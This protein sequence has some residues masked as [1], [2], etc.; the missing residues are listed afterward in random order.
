MFITPSGVYKIN[1]HILYIMANQSFRIYIEASERCGLKL[2][3]LDL[4]ALD[5][6]RAN[7]K[8]AEFTKNLDRK[9]CWQNQ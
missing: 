3:D 1:E 2:N 6:I 7:E 9:K 4:P 8:H 5:I